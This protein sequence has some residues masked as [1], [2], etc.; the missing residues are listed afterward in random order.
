MSKGCGDLCETGNLTLLVA[1]HR[2][3]DTNGFLGCVSTQAAERVRDPMFILHRDVT[4][5]VLEGSAGPTVICPLEVEEV[6]KG[7]IR[8]KLPTCCNETT[9]A[10]VPGGDGRS[11]WRCGEWIIG[12]WQKEPLP[13]FGEGQNV[14]APGS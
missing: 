11:Q 12:V 3:E 10:S 13:P 7:F 8:R 6:K 1:V 14:K 2:D 4:G 9:G 5:H